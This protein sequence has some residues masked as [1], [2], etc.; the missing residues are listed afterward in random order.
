M[1]SQFIDLLLGFSVSL[2]YALCTTVII[3]FYKH[4]AYCSVG[5]AHKVDAFL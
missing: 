1:L 4:F 3:L 5:I 2:S